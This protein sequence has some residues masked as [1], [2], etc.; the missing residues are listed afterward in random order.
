MPLYD[1]YCPS[2]SHEFSEFNKMDERDTEHCPKCKAPAK[3]KLAAPKR[4]TDVTGVWTN[5]DE[6]VHVR[7][8][9]HLKDLCKAQGLN[10]PGALD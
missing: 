9:Q 3:Q 8:K 7:G 2:C 4:G 1:Y 5:F 6:P 10:A